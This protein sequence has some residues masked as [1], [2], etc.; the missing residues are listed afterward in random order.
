[1]TFVINPEGWEEYKGSK[2]S[3]CYQHTAFPQFLV[4]VYGDM[5]VVAQA[6]R[7]L[8][9]VMT[10]PCLSIRTRMSDVLQQYL[11]F[12]ESLIDPVRQF[13]WSQLT[14][15]DFALYRSYPEQEDLDRYKLG[16]YEEGHL[17]CWELDKV[18]CAYHTELKQWVVPTPYHVEVE[19]KTHWGVPVTTVLTF[20]DPM[21]KLEF[22]LRWGQDRAITLFREEV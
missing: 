22:L 2:F 7:Y 3:Y 4:E 18:F 9:E 14:T 20:T 8:Y 12:R 1:M 5:V 16:D 21:K 19:A 17:E 15:G 6:N 10:D 13:M 11:T